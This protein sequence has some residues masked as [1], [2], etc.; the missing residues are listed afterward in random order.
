[1]QSFLDSILLLSQSVLLEQNKDLNRVLEALSQGHLSSQDPLS[2]NLLRIYTS[3]SGPES[4]T[5]HVTL[6][7]M[8]RPE[9]VHEAVRALEQDP[10][11]ESI[12]QTLLESQL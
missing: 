4:T 5:A 10:L 3:L 11:P 1:M 12:L 9:Y 2:Y 6:L 7:G 8:T